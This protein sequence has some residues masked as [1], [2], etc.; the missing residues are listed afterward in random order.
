[1]LPRPN[2]ERGVVGVRDR[3]NDRQ[4]ESQPFP[5]ADA[6]PRQPLEWL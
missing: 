2:L 3:G 5:M 4:A 6:I 1:V